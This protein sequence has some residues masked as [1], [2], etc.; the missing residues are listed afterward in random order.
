MSNPEHIKI[1]FDTMVSSRQ[2][3]DWFP[4]KNEK[5]A[6]G[7]YNVLCGFID[8]SGK[9]SKSNTY[10]CHAP[11]LNFKSSSVLWSCFG[12]RIKE[13]ISRAFLKW[14][15]FE[16]PWSSGSSYIRESLSEFIS[17][18]SLD[19]IFNQGFVFGNLDKIPGNVLHNF[20]VAT[21]MA[22]EWP[23]F[24][25]QW[26]ILVTKYKINPAFAFLF[27]TCFKAINSNDN[28]ACCFDKV[29]ESVATNEDKYDWPLDM[30]RADESYVRNFVA[31]KMV[32]VSKIMFSPSAVTRPVN[33][34]W[35]KLNLLPKSEGTYSKFL[36]DTYSKEF[37]TSKTKV[38]ESFIGNSTKSF[39]VF[40]PN[41][42]ME[43]IELEQKRLGFR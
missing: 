27:I 14:L 3:L 40:T 24:I 39:K 22:A 15:L 12:W 17:N 36:E 37:A 21:R 34:L 28:T 30:A 23:K 16:S 13:N 19:D 7:G 4:F 2:K 42:L 18:N 11:I 41:A 6:T 35:G 31:G 38:V 43:I 25:N 33:S 29:S 8:T 5:F 9:V 26:Y 1:A 32:N 20:L 10:P